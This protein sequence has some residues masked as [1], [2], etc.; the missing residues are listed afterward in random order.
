MLHAFVVRA[1]DGLTLQWLLDTHPLVTVFTVP[2][3][4]DRVR[5]VES[6]TCM[7][8]IWIVLGAIRATDQRDTTGGR[9]LLLG[10]SA[11]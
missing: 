5:R 7:F 1:D 11:F 9:P 4:D 8:T 6:S 2:E 10:L 3:E